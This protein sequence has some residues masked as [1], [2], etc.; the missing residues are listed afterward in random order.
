MANTSRDHAAHSRTPPVVWGLT[1]MLRAAGG[2]A[3]RGSAR[4]P[5]SA[6][7]KGGSPGSR[8]QGEAEAARARPRS[9]LNSRG[10]QGVQA[11]GD[12]A[13]LAASRPGSVR[14]CSAGGPDGRSSSGAS[15]PEPRD[16]QTGGLAMGL[17]ASNHLRTGLAVAALMALT[18]VGAGLASARGCGDVRVYRR[19]YAGQ[20]FS[21]PIGPY[22]P[23]FGP[24]YYRYCR[25]VPVY[26]G[27][28]HGRCRSCLP[29]RGYRM[30]YQRPAPRYYIYYAR[31][32][33]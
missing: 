19:H 11:C 14:G 2:C 33:W 6:P 9:G 10:K 20:G 25:P 31:P 21:C 28:H 23:I 5:L 32:C 30:Y 18:A 12:R 13:K 4:Y 26:P 29:D 15:R 8:R 7:A 16:A 27:P 22:G 24:R 3:G 1:S 17:R